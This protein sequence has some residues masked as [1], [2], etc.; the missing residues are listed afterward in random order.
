MYRRI[1]LL[2]CAFAATG[3]CASL[4][5]AGQSAIPG[6][7]LVLPVALS[8]GGQPIGGIQ[9]DLTADAGLSLGVLPGGQIGVSGKVLY[10][11]SLPN[12]GLRVLIAGLNQTSLADGEVLRPMVSVSASA[13]PGSASVQVS[14]LFAT[15]PNGNAVAL[16]GG[17]AVI[18]IQSSTAAAV[19]PPFVSAG[20]LSAASLLPGPVS[21][22][23]AITIA[24][25]PELASVSGVLF[26]GLPAPLL[27]AGPGQ[28]NAI[29]PLELSLSASADL[30]LTAGSQSLGGVTVPVAAASPALFTRNSNGTGEG[31]ILNQDYTVN[32]AQNP[33]P[34]GSV[35]M[36]YGTG[37]GQV[38]PPGADGQPA[39]DVASTVLP[40]IAS[41]AGVAAQVL[42]AGAAPGL[43]AGVVQ[44]NVRLPGGVTLNPAAQV[45]LTVGGTATA[46]GVTVAVQ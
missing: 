28:V 40:V 38:S 19:G 15:D 10:T 20:V 27:Y 41:V 46:P 34:A 25:G 44:V 22:G 32:S 24:G 2:L 1:G 23:E 35:I 21:P 3:G 26:N 11:A 7:V 4:T 33:A 9:F 13:V 16:I 30:E 42:Y 12:N 37:F 8:S 45:A 18:Q 31:A 14:N 39:P 29:V 43:I 6:Q 5:V 17:A 36:L